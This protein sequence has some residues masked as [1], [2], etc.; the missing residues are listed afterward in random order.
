ME[1]AARLI[2][3]LKLPP[4]AVS[5]QDLAVAAWTSA[6][7][8]RIAARTRPLALVSDR[9]VVEVEDQVWQR[10]LFVLKAQVVR[11]LEEVL[12]QSLVRDVEFRLAVRRREPRRVEKPPSTADEADRIE[13]PVLR[14]IY[15]QQRKRRSA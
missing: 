5:P 3:K 12:G 15:K 2:A 13:D 10:Q 4:G 8:Q 14:S 11:R 7:G 9:L 6:V 1:R